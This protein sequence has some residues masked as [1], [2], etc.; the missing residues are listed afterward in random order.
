VDDPELRVRY[1]LAF[2]LGEWDDPR[3]TQTFAILAQRDARH[4]NILTA[5]A[6]SATKRPGE[7]LR[8]LMAARADLAGVERLVRNLV[9][10]IA[11]NGSETEMASVLTELAKPAL[12]DD[13]HAPWQISAFAQFLQEFEKSK[14]SLDNF[15]A[16]AAAALPSMLASARR[17]AG[18]A[19]QPVERR[20]SAVS[21]LGRDAASQSADAT[22][23]ASLLS[24]RTPDTLQRAAL[25]RLGQMRSEV[26]PAV[27]MQGWSGLSPNIRAQALEVLLRR[28]EW[29]RA[30]LDCLE[31]KQLT[32]EDFGAGARQQLVSHPSDEVRERARRLLAQSISPERQQLVA[33]YLPE[34]TKAAG[35]SSRGAAH[36]A[37]QCAVCHRLNQ[38]GD[39]AGPDLATLVDRSPERML[40]AI[41]DP[42][43]AV[44]DRY[45]NFVAQMRDGEEYSGLLVAESANSITLVS[46]TGARTTLLRSDVTS[47]TSTRRSIMPEGF[48]QFLK[49][50]AMADLL[51]F[52]NAAAV[53]P[54]RFPG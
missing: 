9:T 53:P 19:A 33:Q 10:L 8:A 52:L 29:T 50:P 51:A 3:A 47:L 40:I 15:K 42:N 20:A 16:A 45:L 32:P 7:I 2:T 36:F 46:A 34:V 41:L 21:L 13:T 1:Q 54:R 27:L 49:P 30:L 6:T 11:A 31:A 23:L 25:D 5:I 44:E 48:E 4:E 37:L 22:L 18:N 43:R 17:I 39:G 12:A 35:N 28:D 14:R 24:P 26:V 38:Q